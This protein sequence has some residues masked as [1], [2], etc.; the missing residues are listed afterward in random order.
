MKIATTKIHVEP[1]AFNSERE[2]SIMK[3]LQTALPLLQENLKK[4][5]IIHVSIVTTHF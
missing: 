5:I 4:G 2:T 1:G 3:R